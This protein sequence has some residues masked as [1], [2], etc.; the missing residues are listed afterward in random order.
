[1]AKQDVARKAL[2]HA[3]FSHQ[4]ACYSPDI[5]LAHFDDSRKAVET[6]TRFTIAQDGEKNFP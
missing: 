1:V 6:H 3:G 5:G 2:F 4:F